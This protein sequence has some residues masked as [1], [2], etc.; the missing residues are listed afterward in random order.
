MGRTARHKGRDD[1]TRAAPAPAP[2]LDWTFHGLGE[3]P[4][5]GA[6]AATLALALS[7]GAVAAM[8]PNPLALAMV[9]LFLYSLADFFVPHRYRLDA[10]G[11]WIRTPFSTRCVPWRRVRGYAAA[12]GGVLLTPLPRRSV[13]DRVRGTFL[14][15]TAGQREDILA[16]VRQRLQGSAPAGRA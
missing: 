5:T 14:Y 7:A 15:A 3:R 4:A 8:G 9:T 11:V 6:A 10:A 1:R 12:T 2:E 16:H 13:L